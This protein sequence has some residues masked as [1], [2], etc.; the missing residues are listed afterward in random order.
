MNETATRAFAKRKI[1][2]EIQKLL[3]NKTG[4]QSRVSISRSIPTDAQD[5]PAILIYSTGE[6]VDRFN[7]APK[8]YR[9][10][11]NVNLEI[12][13]AGNDDDHL[14]YILE[15]IGDKVEELMELDETLGG[16]ANKLELSGSSYQSEPDAQSPIGSLVLAYQIEF[17]TDAPLPGSVCLDDF[18]GADTKWKVGHHDSS[19]DNV[20]E[21]EDK[22]DVIT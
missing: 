1:K 14:D 10:T 22:I 13:A 15:D 9:R 19:P 12:I 6:N 21:A 17:F 5:L 2:E 8:N 7:E 16:L 18:K 11:L 4:A 3:L 20:V